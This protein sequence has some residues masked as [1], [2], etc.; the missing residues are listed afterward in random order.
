MI[1]KSKT[2]R[3]EMHHQCLIDKM[4]TFYEALGEETGFGAAAVDTELSRFASLSARVEF[5]KDEIDF[6]LALPMDTPEQ[7]KLKFLAYADTQKYQLVEA[8]FARIVLADAPLVTEEKAPQSPDPKK[9]NSSD[10]VKPG[11]ETSKNSSLS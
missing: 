10:D 11:S 1:V 7:L 6:E 4:S 3:T 2:P 9:K 5:E 8:C